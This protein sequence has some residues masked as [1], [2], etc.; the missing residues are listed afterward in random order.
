[1]EPQFQF[2]HRGSWHRAGVVVVALLT[3]GSAH[4]DAGTPLLWGTAF[5]LFIGN[6][7]LALLEGSLIAGWFQLPWKRCIGWML[8]ANYFSAWVGLWLL[9]HEFEQRVTDLYDARYWLWWLVA[10]AYG[11]TL[12][13]E[14]PFVALCF[15][16]QRCWFRKSLRGAWMTQTLSYAL[17]FGGYAFVSSTSLY[18]E[19][20]VVRAGDMPRPAGIVLFYFS[21]EDGDVWRTDLVSGKKEKVAVLPGERD[22]MDHLKLETSAGDTNFW[23]LV[24][25]IRR[26]EAGPQESC[27]VWPRISSQDRI[28]PEQ[29]RLTHSYFGWGRAFQVASA[30]NSVWELEWTHW[31]DVGVRVSSQQSRFHLGLGVPFGGWSPFRVIHLPGDYALVQWDRQICLVSLPERT[32]AKIGTGTGILALHE[33][34]I[35]SPPPADPE[36][37]AVPIPAR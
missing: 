23:D 9:Q 19:L 28:P 15:W 25:V 36:Q 2:I 24:A 29:A 14:W 10:S 20:E 18:G 12:I 37:A 34:Q 3:A 5:H 22:L 4:A 16:R 7:L 33:S 32:V 6:A 21:P 27:V 17:L 11:L 13:L 35:V 30:T 1:M 26:G 31:E 8:P